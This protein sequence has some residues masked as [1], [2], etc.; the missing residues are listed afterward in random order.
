MI[1]RILAPFIALII[2]LIL[3][4]PKTQAV[5]IPIQE[6]LQIT[7][8]SL[9]AYRKPDAGSKSDFTLYKGMIIQPNAIE[10]KN[11]QIWAKIQAGNQDYWIKTLTDNRPNLKAKTNEHQIIDSYGI[12]KQPHRYA[13]KLVKYTGEPKGRIET[14][15]KTENGYS[16]RSSYGVSYRKNGNKSH[17]SDLKTIGGPV[18]RYMYKTTKSSMNSWDQNGKKMG[19]YKVSYP[20]PHDAL[21]PF[22]KG[23]IGLGHYNKVPIINE[24]NGMFSPHPHS[25]MGADILIHTERWGSRGCINVE[26]EE[27]GKLYHYDLNTEEDREI[28]PLIIYDEGVK[29]PKVGELF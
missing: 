17:Y 7:T 2:G 28:I 21:T 4:A 23:K 8:E 26:N 5:E 16:L 10:V 11:G 15:L 18:I 20:M 12:L 24:K 14:Y 9:K 3:V 27:M 13:V 22:L 19:V 1:K 29:A 25:Y 6:G